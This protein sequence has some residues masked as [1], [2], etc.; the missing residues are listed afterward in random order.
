MHE[1]DFRYNVASHFKCSHCGNVSARTELM[2][3]NGEKKKNLSKFD[4]FDIILTG[5]KSCGRLQCYDKYFLPET[6][7]WKDDKI[8]G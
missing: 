8:S 2:T 4:V 6:D 1:L 5:C 7:L 3:M